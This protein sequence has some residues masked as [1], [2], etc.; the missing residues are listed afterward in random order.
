MYL[1]LL[2][3]LGVGMGQRGLVEPVLPPADLAQEVPKS[4]GD[5]E[6]TVN[7]VHRAPG[8]EAGC[9]V[10]ASDGFCM[11]EDHWRVA[12]ASKE[13]TRESMRAEL[14]REANRFLEDRVDPRVMR[15][16]SARRLTIR[17][18]QKAPYGI[19]FEVIRAC[20][21]VGLYKVEVAAAV[22]TTRAEGRLE[23]WLHRGQPS[24]E[25]RIALLRD[26]QTGRTIRKFRHNTIVDDDH[27][28]R[29]LKEV[30][31]DG[32]RR[33][34]SD[35]PL[36]F[37]AEPSVPWGEVVHLI[38]GAKRGGIETFGLAF[39]PAPERTPR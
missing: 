30:R 17:A 16:L 29:L 4:R 9:P 28:Q 31:A 1:L 12:I 37:D 19:L 20:G 36:F 8:A 10:H 32:A 24:E 38:D 14:E 7:V 15:R 6:T 25:I 35:M 23:M 5:D 26:A 2:S 34:E 39:P 33:N 27:L 21:T 13:H 3:M 18:D 22:P 11:K